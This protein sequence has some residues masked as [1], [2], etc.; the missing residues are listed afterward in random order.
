MTPL[1]VFA[2]TVTVAVHGVLTAVL[3]DTLGLDTASAVFS[4]II[5][6]GVI[7]LFMVWTDFGADS[8]VQK[9]NRRQDRMAPQTHYKQPLLS[10][11]V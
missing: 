1:C 9:W 6:F 8:V 10:E 5:D 11:S 7:E 4:G 3:L 2:W